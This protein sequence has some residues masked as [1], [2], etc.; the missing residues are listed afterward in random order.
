LD[1]ERVVELIIREDGLVDWIIGV[2]LN[3][4][5]IGMRLEQ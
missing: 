4:A 2:L 1:L 5:A 3:R